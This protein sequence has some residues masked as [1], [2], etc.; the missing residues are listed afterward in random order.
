MALRSSTREQRAEWS[1]RGGNSTASR[2]GVDFYRALGKKG[3][4]EVKRRH[5][6]DHFRRMRKLTGC[7]VE[8]KK[9]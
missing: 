8:G 5:G 9:A 4:E 1:A 6:I 7:D 3:G 2:Y